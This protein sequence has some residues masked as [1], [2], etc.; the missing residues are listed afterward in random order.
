[1]EHNIF[2]LEP[3]GQIRLLDGRLAVGGTIDGKTA[4]INICAAVIRRLDDQ[5]V[6]VL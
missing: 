5:I 1:M 4:N 3:V 2:I 6:A